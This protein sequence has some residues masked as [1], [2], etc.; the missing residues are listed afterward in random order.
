MRFATKLQVT[1]EA[2]LVKWLMNCLKF[3]M[4]YIKSSERNMLY[5]SAMLN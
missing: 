2:L 4:N 1:F 3:I 5:H